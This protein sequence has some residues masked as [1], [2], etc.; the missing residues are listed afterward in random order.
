MACGCFR[1]RNAL[2]SYVSLGSR[3]S[4]SQ[5]LL[6]PYIARCAH[7]CQVVTATA[8]Q[9]FS[10]VILIDQLAWRFSAESVHVWLHPHAG[11]TPEPLQ[12]RTRT[13]VPHRWGA[14]IGVTWACCAC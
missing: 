1:I 12:A 2:G 10:T 9:S 13:W 6:L 5:G 8:G 4:R 7:A 11:F 14:S 3:I